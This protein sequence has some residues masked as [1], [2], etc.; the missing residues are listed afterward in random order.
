MK[1]PSAPRRMR[2]KSVAGTP[3]P[4]KTLPLLTGV[5]KTP[6]EPTS[7]TIRY[8]NKF[9]HLKVFPRSPLKPSF[10]YSNPA[11]EEQKPQTGVSSPVSKRK[12]ESLDVKGSACT[13]KRTPYFLPMNIPSRIHS[14]DTSMLKERN[15]AKDSVPKK[16]TYMFK[17]FPIGQPNSLSLVPVRLRRQKLRSLNGFVASEDET[18]SFQVHS[19]S[20]SK[21][22]LMNLLS[23]NG[24][25]VKG[26]PLEQTSVSKEKKKPYNPYSDEQL[27]LELLDSDH[28][29]SFNAL[30][31]HYHSRYELLQS[32]NH[33]PRLNIRS[34]AAQDIVI[35]SHGFVRSSLN[36]RVELSLIHI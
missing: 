7:K 19:E 3:K 6:V 17:N 28:D 32:R 12:A 36:R 33:S 35:P 21:T 18:G 20:P 2:E 26:P 5:S 15:P 23:V 9:N 24:S 10:L 22:K 4:E 13:P 34:S 27:Q 1:R 11:L 16:Q 8:S 25:Q 31:L 29:D 14:N 30:K